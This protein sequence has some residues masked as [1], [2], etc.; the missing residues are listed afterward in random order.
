MDIRYHNDALRVLRGVVLLDQ[1]EVP[2]DLTHRSV[3]ALA[4]LDLGWAT[5]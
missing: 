4:Q 1:G 5:I 3:P 2:G